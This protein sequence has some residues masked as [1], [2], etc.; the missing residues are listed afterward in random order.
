MDIATYAEDH[1]SWGSP[2][3]PAEPG[4]AVPE[5]NPPRFDHEGN[6]WFC[7]LSSEAG[8]N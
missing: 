8:N 2:I 7:G 1:D 3:L 6:E 4:C 5:F